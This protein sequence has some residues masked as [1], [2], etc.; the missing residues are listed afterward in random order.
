[1]NLLLLL[2]TSLFFFG[3]T[4][5]PV[6]PN[7]A[8]QKELVLDTDF[9]DPAI[10]KAKDGYYYAYAT[11]TS[12][13]QGRT[14]NLQ[15]ARSK[16]LQHWEHLGE[17][18]PKKPVWA[19]KTQK[20]WAP[21]V[22]E[23]FAKADTKTGQNA[24]RYILY[25][26]AD[27]NTLTGLCLAVAT[28]SSPTGPFVDG[29]KPLVCGKGFV[30]IDPM[31]FVDPSTNEAY[32]FWGSGFGPIKVQKLS[33]DR[34]QFAKGSA[35]IDLVFPNPD[36]TSANFQKLVE[37]A[38]VMQNDGWNYLFFSGDNCC[39]PDPH[40]AV[41][42]ARSRN[43]LGPYEVRKAQGSSFAEP[44]VKADERW[45]APGHNSVA[46]ADDGGAWIFY[47]AIDQKQRYLRTKIEGDRNVRRVLLRSGLRFK[48][49]WPELAN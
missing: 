19:S 2:L 36:K 12:D 40:Y 4:T 24:T 48:N 23:F 21:H 30:N 34:L 28:A 49:G 14:T 6:L 42:V 47:H 43:L 9:P 33:E 32:L 39:E 8:N 5:K 7:S 1:M 37:G 3:C 10:L 20:I 31:Q 13:E 22:A 26:S 44:L 45:L 41:M 27:P 15:V 38:W 25:Y 11:Q 46:T 35:A 16:D 29:G 18:L 17:A